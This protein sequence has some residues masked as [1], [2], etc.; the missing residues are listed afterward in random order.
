MC[1][2]ERCPNFSGRN[3]LHLG[4]RSQK[5]EVL[6]LRT[7]G[8]RTGSFKA[9][10][11]VVSHRLQE[12]EKQTIPHRNGVII[13]LDQRLFVQASTRDR[14]RDQDVPIVNSARK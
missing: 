7:R 5:S 11:M 1:C 2:A 3:A 12:A 9:Y 10:L 13:S 8:I 6:I 4:V 14:N